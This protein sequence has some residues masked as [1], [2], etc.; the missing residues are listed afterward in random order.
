MTARH[1]GEAGSEY[2]FSGLLMMVRARF[3]YHVQQKELGAG[4]LLQS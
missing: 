3:V 1:T 2:S 4:L